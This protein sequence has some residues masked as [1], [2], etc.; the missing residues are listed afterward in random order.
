MD[1]AFGVS[2]GQSASHF[3]CELDDGLVRRP[4]FRFLKPFQCRPFEHL[5]CH[6]GRF[7][8]FADLENGG[9]VVVVNRSHRPRFANETRPTVRGC[10]DFAIHDFERDRSF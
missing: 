9:D 6:E 8:F 2:G 10:R 1:D 7:V 5:H 4:R 3:F